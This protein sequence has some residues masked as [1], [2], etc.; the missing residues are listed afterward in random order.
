MFAV[1]KAAMHAVHGLRR[2][3]VAFFPGAVQLS[4]A[5]WSSA[6][7]VEVRFRSSKGD[8][9]RQGAV[10]T[11]T[12]EGTPHR[13]DEGGGAIDL[14]VELLSCFPSLPS[15]A[16]LVAVGVGGGRWD[17]LT[18]HRAESALRQVVSWAGLEP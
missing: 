16:P 13:V 3:D 9:L 6:D 17:L 7:R 5:Q 12:R 8:Q 14:V 18:K 4:E 10:L 2:G 15:H 11:R 1:P